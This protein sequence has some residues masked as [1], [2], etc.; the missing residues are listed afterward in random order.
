M[1][2]NGRYKRLTVQFNEGDLIMSPRVS[3]M[4]KQNKRELILKSAAACFA[5][6]GFKSTT[7]DDIAAHSKTSKGTV[8][9]YFN[10]KE[11]IFFQ[12]NED[13]TGEDLGKIRQQ[14]KVENNAAAKLRKILAF[15]YDC[16]NDN[17]EIEFAS[18]QVEFLLY[19]SR[20]PKMRDDWKNRGKNTWSFIEEVIEEGIQNGEFRKDLN[21]EDFSRIIST[22]QDGLVMHLI[23]DKDIEKYKRLWRIF[24]NMIMELVLKK[25]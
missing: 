2:Q 23:M 6:K 12:L 9:L 24:E 1:W 3:D 13:Y 11:D 19:I 21:Q 15:F 16:S 7:I 4:Y 20:D 10:S 18:L 14:I 17:G 22:I 5:K 8:Y 25:G